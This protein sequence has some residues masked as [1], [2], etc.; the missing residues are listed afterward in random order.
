MEGSVG[1][2]DLRFRLPVGMVLLLAALGVLQV[3]LGLESFADVAA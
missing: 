2:E 1:F 3:A